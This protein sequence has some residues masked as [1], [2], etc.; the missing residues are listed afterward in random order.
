MH[1]AENVNRGVEIPRLRRTG[2]NGRSRSETHLW[3]SAAGTAIRDYSPEQGNC[4]WA[5]SLVV[6]LIDALHAVLPGLSIRY[7]AI[8]GQAALTACFTG[9][10][11]SAPAPNRT[12]A[13]VGD[14]SALYDLDALAL[15]RQ[16]SAPLC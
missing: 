12:L 16:V 15:L 7:T 5:I 11:R 8:A 6:R 9:G 13:I 3:R 14:L 1:P 2:G 10:G 4:S